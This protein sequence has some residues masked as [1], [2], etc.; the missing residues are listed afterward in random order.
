MPLI[1]L[2]YYIQS[3]RLQQETYA[4]FVLCFLLHSAPVSANGN[5]HENT[6]NIQHMISIHKNTFNT[7]IYFNI[8]IITYIVSNSTRL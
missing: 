1:S 6:G 4:V 2:S 3:I 5:Y 7:F 8:N